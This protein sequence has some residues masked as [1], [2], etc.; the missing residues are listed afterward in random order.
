MNAK[1]ITCYQCASCSLIYKD[2][3]VTDT[4]CKPRYC[5]ECKAEIKK[6]YSNCQ[7]CSS[8]K[9]NLKTREELDKAETVETYEGMLYDPYGDQY[10]SDIE[11]FIE[12]FDPDELQNRDDLRLFCTTLFKWEGLSLDIEETIMCDLQDGNHHEDAFDE[13]R[14]IEEL[15]EFMKKWNAKQN[16][17]SYGI[18]YSKKIVIDEDYVEEYMEELYD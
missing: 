4:C 2:L 6:G 13:V 14:D 5:S 17:A 15:I 12:S 18:D 9:D 10:H 3:E 1:P 16:V 7:S 11:S 8:Y